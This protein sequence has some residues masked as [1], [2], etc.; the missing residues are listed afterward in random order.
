[1]LP[2]ALAEFIDALAFAADKHRH[3]R[4]KDVHASPYINHPIELV[5]VLSVEGG[6]D[7]RV[8]LLA[9][10]LHDT[11]EDTETTEAELSARFG[12][13]VAEVVM[14]VTDDKALAKAERKA[15]QVEHAPHLSRAAALVKLADKICNLRDMAD[16][17]PAQWSL[18]RRREYFDWARRVIDGLRGA[19]PGLEAAFD[20][21]YARRP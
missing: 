4:R 10:L 3:Q 17:P 13:E 14:E 8:P 6:I 20:A 1:V 16:K 15:A 12:G 7:G 18:E 19:H 2:P 21:A 9:A 11:V 5:R